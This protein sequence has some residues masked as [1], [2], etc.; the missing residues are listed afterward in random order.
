MNPFNGIESPR[1][2]YDWCWADPGNPFN[3]IESRWSYR[4]G[5]RTSSTWIHS[6]E[7]KGQSP[8][9]QDIHQ[10]HKNPFNGI[11]SPPHLPRKRKRCGWIHSMELKGTLAVGWPGNTTLGIHSMELKDEGLS[12]WLD[13]VK[14]W[15]IHSMELKGRGQSKSYILVIVGIHSMELKGFNI[16]GCVHLR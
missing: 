7:L 8:G 1:H 3:G 10:H 4:T 16:L 11:E 12:R 5:S 9:S 15:R 14:C 13:F 6:M 2:I